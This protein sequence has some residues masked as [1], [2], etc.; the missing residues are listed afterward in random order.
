[1]WTSL[2][3]WWWM[4]LK[5]AC[6]LALWDHPAASSTGVSVVNLAL[7]RISRI[8]WLKVAKCE[9]HVEELCVQEK[10]D[11]GTWNAKIFVVHAAQHWHDP[12]FTWD[13]I[14]VRARVV[15][16]ECSILR[17]FM[18]IS[19]SSPSLYKGVKGANERMKILL[20]R[21]EFIISFSKIYSVPSLFCAFVHLYIIMVIPWETNLIWIATAVADH[22]TP[23]FLVFKRIFNGKEMELARLP[24]L[25]CMTSPR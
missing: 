23:S 8:M 16:E 2:R 9:N 22:Y 1:M 7:G 12:H 18:L 21:Q 17:L 6:R 10:L 14:R 19:N 15:R 3:F 24:C 4:L 20:A 13:V 25:Q 11:V 5:T